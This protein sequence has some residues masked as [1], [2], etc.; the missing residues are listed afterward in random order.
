MKT[1]TWALTAKVFYL[2][3]LGGLNGRES[4]QALWVQ[5]PLTQPQME[6]VHHRKSYFGRDFLKS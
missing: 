2:L 4:S 5:L 6:W 3:E 1:G